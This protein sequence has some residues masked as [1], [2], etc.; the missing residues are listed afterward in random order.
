MADR[1]WSLVLVFGRGWL[2]GALLGL[3]LGGGIGTFYAPVVGTFYG[4]FIG[5][6][7]GAIV[8]PAAAALVAPAALFPPSIVGDRV[9]PGVVATVLTYLLC[10]EVVFS[11]TYGWSGWSVGDV[12]VLAALACVAGVL[13]ACFGPTMVRGVRIRLLRAS[14]VGAVGA[15]VGGLVAAGRFVAIE[16]W[17]EPALLIA[18]TVGGLV[19]GGILSLTLVAF[20]LL[21][22][23]EPAAE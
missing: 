11:G 18:L 1:M 14:H 7:I 22:T 13:S 3:V 17:S 6:T 2:F 4:G 15:A 21:V 20:D 12:S 19:S 8:G 23:K 10:T 16:G 9:W 5:G